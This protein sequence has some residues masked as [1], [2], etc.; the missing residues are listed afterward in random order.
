MLYDCL[1]KLIVLFSVYNRLVWVKK[2]GELWFHVLT[3]HCSHHQKKTLYQILKSLIINKTK[4]KHLCVTLICARLISKDHMVTVKWRICSFV[5]SFC[6]CVAWNSLSC[7]N[8]SR[9]FPFNWETLPDL[10]NTPNLAINHK[11]MWN[12]LIIFAVAANYYVIRCL[13]K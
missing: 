9:S 4:L 8:A 7:I 10:F 13:S 3:A 11:F 1:H 5:F 2:T 12:E 6:P